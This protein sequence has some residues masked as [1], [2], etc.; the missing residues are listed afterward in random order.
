LFYQTNIISV[1]RFKLLICLF[2]YCD[3]RRRNGQA[4]KTWTSSKLGN[5]RISLTWIRSVTEGTCKCERFEHHLILKQRSVGL[6][7]KA[8]CWIVPRSILLNGYFSM[9]LSLYP[10]SSSRNASN[11]ITPEIKYW[12]L[13]Y[14]KSMNKS[15]K[16]FLQF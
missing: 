12:C 4:W 13:R 2:I 6:R 5:T 8:L 1:W 15:K 16:C 14:A 9:N 10:H 11:E 3:Y 7:D